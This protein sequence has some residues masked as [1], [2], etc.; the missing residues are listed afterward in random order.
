M[1]L[2]VVETQKHAD[3]Y[4][5]SKPRLGWARSAFLEGR[6]DPD[7]ESL[8]D[9]YK[10]WRD[11]PEYLVLQRQSEEFGETTR[12]TV[13]VKCSKRGND[14]YQDRVKKRFGG[15]ER[16]C[17]GTHDVEFFKFTDASPKVKMIFVTLTW[18]ARG[19]IS[20]SWETVGNHF[21]RWISNLRQKFGP[22]SYVRTWEASQKGYTHVHLMILFHQSTFSGFKTLDQDGNFVWRISEKSELEASWPAFIDCRAVRTASAVI[23]YIRKRVLQ[24]TDKGDVESGDL[25]LALCWVFRK[26]SFAMSGDLQSSLGDLIARLHNSKLQS[27]LDGGFVKEIW[28]CLGIFSAAEIGLTGEVWCVELDKVPDDAPYLQ[29]GR[30]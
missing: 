16:L 26:R 28:V 21:N 5:G 6:Q 1:T 25:T 12:K 4:E 24:G 29:G 7:L 9:F 13:A 10:T 20:E 8:V 17:C 3:L 11:F 18:V 14:V 15:L 19:R 22:L 23:R 27:C 30:G 2:S